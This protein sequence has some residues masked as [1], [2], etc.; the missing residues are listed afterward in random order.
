MASQYLPPGYSKV[1]F[2]YTYTGSTRFFQNSLDVR[3]L[4][5][6]GSPSVVLANVRSAM[7]AAS[8]PYAAGEVLTGFTMTEAK[9]LMKTLGGILLT[10]VNSIPIV[11]TKSGTG[12]PINTSVIVRKTVAQAGKAYRGRLLVPPTYF[13][14]SGI[15]V[16]GNITSGLA[17]YQTLW[18][19]TFADLTGVNPVV[20]LHSDPALV[21]TT[22]TQ[23]TVNSKIGTIGKRMRG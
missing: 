2:T 7:T 17:A 11:G 10:D 15:D 18:N 8:H 3:N 12:G 20:L 9:I 13:P 22:L 4:L 5:N 6:D 19:N 21:P 14:E 16:L 23:F 1:T